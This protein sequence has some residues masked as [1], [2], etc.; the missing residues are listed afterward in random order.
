MNGHGT[1][2]SVHGSRGTSFFRWDL[3]FR[4][5]PTLLEFFE[6][7]DHRWLA[8]TDQFGELHGVVRFTS[9]S[10]QNLATHFVLQQMEDSIKVAHT[11]QPKVG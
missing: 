8:D 5:Q 11:S 2:N 9:E 7:F 1:F 4:N 6:V 10:F 3:V